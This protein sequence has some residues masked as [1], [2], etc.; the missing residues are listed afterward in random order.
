MLLEILLN[1][2]LE[3]LLGIS[4]SLGVPPGISSR[5]LQH[6]LLEFILMIF[7][8]NI[9]EFTPKALGENSPGVPPGVALE[10][11]S[12]ILPRVSS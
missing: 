10:I 2:S 3:A 6:L 12:P 5:T 8:A 9:Q 1:I 11:L 4:L 7:H